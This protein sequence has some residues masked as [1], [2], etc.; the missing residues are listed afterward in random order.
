MQFHNNFNNFVLED[1][2][3]KEEALEIIIRIDND[4]QYKIL[5]DFLRDFN[6]EYS[7][8]FM[9]LPYF[10]DIPPHYYF[11][12][13]DKSKVYS[14]PG[15]VT[16][17]STATNASAIH[18]L[19]NHLTSTSSQLNGVYDHIYTI[20]DLNLIRKILSSNKIIDK[21]TPTYMLSP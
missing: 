13:I 11:L 19:E 14:V 3:T 20:K 18:D 5:R 12:C 1:R 15:L 8:M 17:Y 16:S 7:D 10:P 6:L 21:P 4:E 9:T 2:N